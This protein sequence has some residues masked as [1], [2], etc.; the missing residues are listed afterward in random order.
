MRKYISFF[1]IT[2]VASLQ[3]RAAAFAGLITQFAWGFL[4]LMMFAAFYRADSN[5]FPMPFEQ[6]SSYIWLQ[7]A[8]LMMLA[9]WIFDA[10]LFD[11]I[12]N[13]NIAYELAR[14]TDMYFMWF[15]KNMAKRI[16][17]TVLRA[18]PVLIVALLL[19]KPYGLSL[20]S[21]VGVFILFLLSLT[22]GV[23]SVLAFTMII[24]GITF[25]TMNSRGVRIIAIGMSDFLSGQLV[26]IPFMPPVVRE[27]MEL[28]PFATIQNIPFRIYS[29]N[30]GGGDIVFGM[31]LQLF[32]GV[33]MLGGGRL[34]M[35]H[36]L[37]RTV[38]QGG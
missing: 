23:I 4:R 29:G 36:A 22:M 9:T 7:Q 16:A 17:S 27:I 15:T 38:V 14:P 19:P 5:A 20:P 12:T 8:L 35:N 32:W 26:P 13:G 2:F 3:Y 11:M 6:F 25:F 10:E 34:L 24:Y 31:F 33:V 21:S 37:K 18:V 30:I 28:T 1:R